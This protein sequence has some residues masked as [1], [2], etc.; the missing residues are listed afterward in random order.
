MFHKPL[1][2]RS[3]SY[4][5]G[6]VGSVGGRD[7]SGTLSVCLEHFSPG[8]PVLILCFDETSLFPVHTEGYRQDT[9]DL[10]CSD[11]RRVPVV[12]RI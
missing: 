5:F 10:E 11:G 2:S 6:F 1:T 4:G 7:G 8:L 9:G 12:H 3:Q